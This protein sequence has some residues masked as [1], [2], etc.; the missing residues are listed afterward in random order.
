MLLDWL[1]YLT[2]PAP[3][4]FRRVG[5]V[6]DSIWLLSRSRRCRAAWQTHLMRSRELVIEIVAGLRKRR[7]V[8]VL[9]SGLLDDVPLEA[10]ARSFESVVLVDVVHPWPARAAMRRHGNVRLVEF[11]LSGCVDWMLG[12]SRDLGPVLPDICHASDVD[13][14]ISANVL[15]QLPIL[16]LDWFE[17][18][19]GLPADLGSRIVSAHLDGLTALATRVCLVTD[20]TQVDTDR[21]GDI[22][23]R[24]D[25]LHG[26][27]LGMPD[28]EWEWELAPFGEAA[29]GS[30]LVHQVC[31]F[32]D[33]HRRL[34]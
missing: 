9:G 16:P 28:R 5:F 19:G 32:G 6:R 20:I 25:L 3:K 17:A 26:I 30:R 7:T 23:D 21:A 2:T 1:H 24:S 11:D 8:V 10:L 33:W 13:L 18:R 27:V 29:R 15:S 22:I 34:K 12:R 31:G 14:V 4:D